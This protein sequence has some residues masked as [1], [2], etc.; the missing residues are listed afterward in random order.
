M[1]PHTHQK[2]MLIQTKRRGGGEEGVGEGGGEEGERG[3]RGGRRERM[4]G[5]RRERV[6]GRKER[7]RVEICPRGCLH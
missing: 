5:R 6:E 2:L 1:Y 3:W 7:E 4:E